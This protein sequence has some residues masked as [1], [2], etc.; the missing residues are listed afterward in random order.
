MQGVRDQIKK[1]AMGGGTAAKEDEDFYA[2]S[3]SESDVSDD[4]EEGDQRKPYI[5]FADSQN[6]QSIKIIGH[7]GLIST[8]FKMLWSLRSHS[9]GFRHC[10]LQARH[11]HQRG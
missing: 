8:N 4:E 5:G 2:V 11:S 7:C 3:S 10:G 1:M 6:T 9:N